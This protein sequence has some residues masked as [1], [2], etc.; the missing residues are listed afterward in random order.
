MY[1]T[2]IGWLVA[3]GS[4]GVFVCQEAVIGFGEKHCLM[5]KIAPNC[6]FR[7]LAEI[8]VAH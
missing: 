2:F 1:A 7:A 4:S 6:Q 8:A 5:P 3:S